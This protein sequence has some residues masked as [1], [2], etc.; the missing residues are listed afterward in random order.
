MNAKEDHG[1]RSRASAGDGVVGFAVL[2][3]LLAGV[4]A[5]FKAF[6]ASSGLDTL[7]CTLGAVFAFGAVAYLLL[8]SALE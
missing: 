2:G 4:V 5:V 1:S 7:L 6:V 3:C 8:S